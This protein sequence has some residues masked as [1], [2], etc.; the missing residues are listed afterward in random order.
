MHATD[1]I[2][3]VHL[4]NPTTGEGIGAL[5]FLDPDDKPPLLQSKLTEDMI[6][7]WWCVGDARN[8]VRMWVQ[9]NPLL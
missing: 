8:R 7:K 4:Y 5:D 2:P 6:E 1:S 9:G 3:I